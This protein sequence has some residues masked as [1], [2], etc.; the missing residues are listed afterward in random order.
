[1]ATQQTHPGPGDDDYLAA[2]FPNVGIIPLTQLFKNKEFL[3]AVDL[4]DGQT[5]RRASM[6][7]QPGKRSLRR[8]HHQETAQRSNPATGQ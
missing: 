7:I 2:R 8:D 3:A 5:K 1:M 6:G 4:L